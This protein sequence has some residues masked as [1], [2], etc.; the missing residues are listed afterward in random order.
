MVLIMEYVL[1]I[2]NK[3]FKVQISFKDIKA[4]RLKVFPSTEIK[5]S[6]PLDTPENFIV[7][8][9]NKK[10]LWIEKQLNLF[11]QT[12][13]VEKEQTIRLGTATRILGRQLSIKIIHA[14]RKRIEQND[15]WLLIYTPNTALQED[16]DRQFFNWWQKNSK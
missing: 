1:K 10:R 5:L 11:C 12:Q 7:N 9:L 6:V 3:N 16:I 4:L 2:S 13:A 15:R 8:F 14:T